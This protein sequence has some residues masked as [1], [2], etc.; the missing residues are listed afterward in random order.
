MS[1]ANVFCVLGSVNSTCHLP[2]VLHLTFLSSVPAVKG[3][4]IHLESPLTY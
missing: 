1:S 4:H 2:V 3:E